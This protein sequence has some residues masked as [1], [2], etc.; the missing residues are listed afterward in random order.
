MVVTTLFAE[1]AGSL[2]ATLDRDSQRALLDNIHRRVRSL[3]AH[4]H[5]TQSV[6]DDVQLWES[7]FRVVVAGIQ[8]R[9]APCLQIDP[10]GLLAREYLVEELV[11]ADGT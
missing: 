11:G 10:R 9:E 1:I 2:E 4:E 7:I 5:Q 8:E 3:Q 6:V